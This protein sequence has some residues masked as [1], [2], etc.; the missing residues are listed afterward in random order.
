MVS[1]PGIRHI[2]SVPITYLVPNIT[3]R[4]LASMSVPV[5][6]PPSSRLKFYGD[7]VCD[8]TSA[9]DNNTRIEKVTL[10]FHTAKTV[11]TTPVAFVIRTVPGDTYIYRYEGSPVPRG[12]GRD[13]HRLPRWRRGPLKGP[14]HLLRPQSTSQVHL[15]TKNNKSEVPDVINDIA[16]IL[17]NSHKF[18]I[19]S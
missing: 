19:N 15:L 16:Q 5:Y 13:H 12:Q 6:I 18:P 8:V 3:Y 1:L 14:S 4:A 9:D 17:N 2:Y 11:P 10:T 7:A